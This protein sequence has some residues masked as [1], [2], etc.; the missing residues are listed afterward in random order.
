M[1]QHRDILWEV[2]NVKK[3][4]KND[5]PSQIKGNQFLSQFFNVCN[6]KKR[7]EVKLEGSMETSYSLSQKLSI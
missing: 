3:T 2:A 5:F 1:S 7:E 4:E 6:K